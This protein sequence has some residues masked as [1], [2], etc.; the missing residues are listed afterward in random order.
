MIIIII[1]IIILLFSLTF[2]GKQSFAYE[3]LKNPTPDLE[4]Y[5]FQIE[6]IKRIICSGNYDYTANLPTLIKKGF[7]I[8]SAFLSLDNID[9]R[10]LDAIFAF[11]R[12]M[13]VI[14]INWQPNNP[15]LI[16]KYDNIL[17]ENK[18]I[19]YLT[20]YS[21]LPKTFEVCVKDLRY[22]Y[23]EMKLSEFNEI[24]KTRRETLHF[25]SR[26]D[27]KNLESY[28]LFDYFNG[29]STNFCIENANGDRFIF[30]SKGEKKSLKYGILD[31]GH[32]HIKQQTITNMLDYFDD[33]NWS[34]EELLINEC[35]VEHI[36]DF[37][38][39]KPK[40]MNL[41]QTKL[42]P[43]ILGYNTIMNLTKLNIHTMVNGFNQYIRYLPALTN[44]RNLNI[45]NNKLTNLSFIK[46]MKL[47][48][49]TAS[50][51]RI[52]IIDFITPSL[53]SLNVGGNFINTIPCLQNLKILKLD[54]NFLLK[55]SKD[56]N[57]FYKLLEK[58]NIEKISLL[59]TKFENFR[60]DK[61]SR[62]FE[63]LLPENEESLKFYLK[64]K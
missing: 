46:Q 44:L 64:A 8:E 30:D 48:K 11:L 2:G 24:S 59:G 38:N 56:F 19:K 17:C 25:Y 4:Y 37:K 43:E 41:G 27:K 63:I 62:K 7:K 6:S 42:L 54:N 20:S 53:T 57:N 15:E 50:K 31:V 33:N 22:V 45:K 51:N 61:I 35:D 12:N 16:K 40:Y 29:S 13:P 39:L 34:I 21:I 3:K 60:V 5:D 58:S 36:K 10:H 9:N 49:L 14:F 47:Q 52:K 1:I 18:N 32:S 23:D 28:N 55:Y 26:G